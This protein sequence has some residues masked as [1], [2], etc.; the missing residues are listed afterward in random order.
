[1]T[2]RKFLGIQFDCCGTYSRIY[3]NKENTAYTGNCPRCGKAIRVK[4]GPGGTENRFPD[5]FVSFFSPL[6]ITDTH[7]IVFPCL[8]RITSPT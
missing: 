6:P 2:K 5:P 1:M 4:I 3:A 7:A 8:R